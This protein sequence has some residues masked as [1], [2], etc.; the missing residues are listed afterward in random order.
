MSCQANP[1]QGRKWLASG[2][3]GR[4]LRNQCHWDNGWPR[5]SQACGTAADKPSYIP[6]HLREEHILPAENVTL[7]NFTT[8]ERCEMAVGYIVH[9]YEV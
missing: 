9:M 1:V 4:G 2:D 8:V 6:Q 3:S 7:A 5:K